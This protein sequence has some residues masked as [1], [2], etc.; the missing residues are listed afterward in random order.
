MI[1]YWIERF[2]LS[3]FGP[4][5]ALIVMA[6]HS[7]R[8]AHPTWLIDIGIV[9]LLL[10]QFRLW[11]DL[12]DRRHD[13]Q[14]HPERV[15]ARAERPGPFVALCL[16]L[17]LLNVTIAWRAD[18][19]AALVLLLL[20]AMTAAWYMLRSGQRRVTGDLVLLAKY[21]LFVLIVAA[22]S[23]R[24]QPAVVSIAMMASLLVAVTCEAWHDP[25]GPL[26]GLLRIRR[27]PTTARTR[28]ADA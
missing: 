3:L 21:P 9:T 26:A 28:G 1:R 6:A 7:F 18:T 13:R 20:D 5:A 2:P 12:A 23:S 19:I 4:V 17:A 11:D 14:T 24:V 15:L 25:V 16:A 10:A 8:P 22:G 27:N